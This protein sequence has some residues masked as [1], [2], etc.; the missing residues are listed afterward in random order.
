MYCLHLPK[1]V[2]MQNQSTCTAAETTMTF[3]MSTAGE[4][5]SVANHR[6]VVQMVSFSRDLRCTLCSSDEG[7]RLPHDAVCIVFRMIDESRL[8]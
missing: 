1:S 6:E 7:N 3:K 2:N 8:H 4:L 5:D